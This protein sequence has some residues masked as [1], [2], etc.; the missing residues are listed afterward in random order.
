MRLDLFEQLRMIVEC[1][2]VGDSADDDFGKPAG[3]V[4]TASGK[5]TINL[6]AAAFTS[7]RAVI[8]K[9]RPEAAGC[10]RRLLGR[11]MVRLKI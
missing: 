2:P 10:E 6:D 1:G 5:R 4:S 3:L 11:L 7:G 8:G 9:I